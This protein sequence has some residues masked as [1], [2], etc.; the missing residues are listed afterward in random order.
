[1]LHL[2]AAPVIAIKHDAEMSR[3]TPTATGQLLMEE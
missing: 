2:T 1:M 3:S